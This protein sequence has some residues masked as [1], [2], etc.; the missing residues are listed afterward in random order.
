MFDPRLRS[1]KPKYFQ[2]FE[3]CSRRAYARRGNKVLTGIDTRLLITMDTLREILMEIDPD[4][5]ALTCCDWYY[6]GKRQYSCLRLANEP[7]STD[8]SLHSRGSA[9]DLISK[10]YM[11]DELRAIIIKNRD[12]LPYLT[13][14]EEGVSWLHIDVANLPEEASVGE[15]VMFTKTGKVRYI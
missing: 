5:A 9:A 14:M 2:T 3:L 7:Y 8:F 15:I 10:H 4:K 11:A 1:Y 12:R 13:R 6:G